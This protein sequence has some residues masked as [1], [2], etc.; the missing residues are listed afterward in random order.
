M[1]SS[2]VSNAT[3]GTNRLG[4]AVDSSAMKNSSNPS[5]IEDRA[6]S[7]MRLTLPSSRLSN[8]LRINHARFSAVHNSKPLHHHLRKDRKMPSNQ[9]KQQQ[10]LRQIQLRRRLVNRKL[11]TIT[12]RDKL[13]PSSIRHRRSQTRRS[14]RQDHHHQHRR[15]SHNLQLP[16]LLH[17]QAQAP[18]LPVKI[19]QLQRQEAR[20]LPQHQPQCLNHLLRLRLRL[21][22][23]RSPSAR[24][25][26]SLMRR[27][28]RILG[29]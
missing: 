13:S 27:L 14:H 15:V 18:N 21:R 3:S 2:V 17:P 10:L 19:N 25:K 22:A 12:M 5:A 9:H 8:R 28:T 7:S 16:P 11:A 23:I 24:R 4:A 29:M 6:P 20:H 26:M 1:K